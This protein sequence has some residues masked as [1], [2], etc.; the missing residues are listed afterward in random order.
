MPEHS[1]FSNLLL[2]WGVLLALLYGFWWGMRR[3]GYL[4][5]GIHPPTGSGGQPAKIRRLQVLES[6]M[7]DPKRRLLLVRCDDAEHLILLGVGGETLLP[8]TPAKTT[9]KTVARKTDG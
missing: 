5:G 7:L 8:I 2:G 1:P 6:Q 4:L 9:G 3:W